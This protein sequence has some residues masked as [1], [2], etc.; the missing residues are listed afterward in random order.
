MNKKLKILV[1]ILL[2]LLIS[3]G[4]IFGIDYF[5]VANFKMPIFVI[6]NGVTADD[7]GSGTYYGIGY[8]VE[9]EKN[10]SAI[11]TP[12]KPPLFSYHSSGFIHREIKIHFM[13]KDFAFYLF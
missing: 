10:V 11:I 5:R 8:R 13:G 3:W 1:I 12:K 2:V 9:V 6:S 4:I 7:G